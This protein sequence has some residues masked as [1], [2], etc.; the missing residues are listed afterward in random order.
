MG[1]GPRNG[2]SPSPANSITNHSQSKTSRKGHG[3]PCNL[4]QAM[5]K[6]TAECIPHILFIECIGGWAGWPSHRARPAPR[7]TA[8][9]WVAR[10]TAWNQKGQ[11]AG[12]QET[13][14]TPGRAEKRQFDD[15]FNQQGGV[16]VCLAGDS[17]SQDGGASTSGLHDGEPQTLE[18]RARSQTACD[19]AGHSVTV[20]SE[21][22]QVADVRISPEIDRQQAQAVCGFL[23]A[24]GLQLAVVCR[25]IS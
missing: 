13:R 18:R 23:A 4:L 11:P 14:K 7:G 17:S 10:R 20:G 1:K 2:G 3:P 22:G 21:R 15:G 16:W 6:I 8:G 12:R 5:S 25:V 24:C 19:A 9:S